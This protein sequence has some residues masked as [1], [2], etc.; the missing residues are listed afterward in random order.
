MHFHRDPAPIHSPVDVF[1]VGF[2]LEIDERADLDPIRGYLQVQS[3]PLRQ[4]HGDISAGIGQIEIF[5]QVSKADIDISPT[6]GSSQAAGK[7]CHPYIAAGSAGMQFPIDL[8]S[9]YITA[10]SACP[11][12][13]F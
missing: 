1:L 8:L 9:P 10:G 4:L 6:G 7:I 13:T 11:D 2:T 5:T 3:L 12:S